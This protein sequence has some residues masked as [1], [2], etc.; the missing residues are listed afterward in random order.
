MPPAR[1]LMCQHLSS[2][3]L[4]MVVLLYLKGWANQR[5]DL[6]CLSS[7]PGV[8]G[9]FSAS[10]IGSSLL[11]TRWILGACSGA[12]LSRYIILCESRTQPALNWT[13]FS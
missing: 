11:D 10:C 3:K 13:C 7:R 9:L 6:S 12:T 8:R 1:P 2:C 5:T 4:Q